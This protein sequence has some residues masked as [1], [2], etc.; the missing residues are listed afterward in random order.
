[1]T[2]L[3]MLF[4]SIEDIF[5]AILNHPFLKELSEGSLNEEVFR[6]Y[7]IQDY[8]YLTNY[9]K[10]LSLLSSKMPKEEWQKT[11]IEDAIGV[12][13]VE[14]AMQESFFSFWNID[15]KK[16]EEVRPNQVTLA[17]SNHL[18]STIV[19][20][21]YPIGIS[22]V[23]P[24]YWIYLEVGKKLAEESSPNPLYKK[25]IETYS[26]NIKYEN[27]VNRILKIAEETFSELDEKALK[28]VKRTFRL[29][30]IYEYM[31]FDAVY[32]RNDFPFEF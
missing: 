11:F 8:I 23:L 19:L 5:K 9:S 17:Y 12:Y 14:K 22:S 25:W 31:F 18:I 21:D 6:E 1:M 3:N 27:I 32:K 20:E 28:K 24:C 30:T 15:R 10:A 26:I 29:S 13:E 2:V 16:L 7:I 4:D